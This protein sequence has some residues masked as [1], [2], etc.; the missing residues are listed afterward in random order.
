MSVAGLKKQFH[1]AS[2]VRRRLLLLV[3]NNCSDADRVLSGAPNGIG[4]RLIAT[5]LP[6]NATLCR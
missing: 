2:Q 4:L 6:L 5:G 1:K 3:H